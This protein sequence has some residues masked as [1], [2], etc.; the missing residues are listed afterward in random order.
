MKSAKNSRISAGVERVCTECEKEFYIGIT[1]EN[2]H[3][4]IRKGGNII[5]Y[6]CGYACWRIASTKVVDKRGKHSREKKEG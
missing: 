3:Y 2:W 5:K 4:K 1:S 6:Q